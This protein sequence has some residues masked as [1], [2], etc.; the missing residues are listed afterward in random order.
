MAYY[1]TNPVELVDWTDEK[2]TLIKA[3]E[4]IRFIPIDGTTYEK[5]LTG[6]R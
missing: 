3:G 4:F 6:G 5:L 1:W 2:L